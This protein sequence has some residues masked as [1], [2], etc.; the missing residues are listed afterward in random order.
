MLNRFEA[1]II[2]EVDERG[3]IVSFESNDGTN[4]TNV[5]EL[6]EN[7]IEEARRDGKQTVMENIFKS[8][9]RMAE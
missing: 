4:L 1:K 2:M 9:E 5:I 6:Y 3:V 8:I 7:K